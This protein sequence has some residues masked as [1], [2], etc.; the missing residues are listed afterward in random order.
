MVPW[1]DG[2]CIW[3]META[4]LT[5]TGGSREVDWRHCWRKQ[6]SAS[7]EDSQECAVG[8]GHE[9][10]HSANLSDTSSDPVIVPEDHEPISST[11]IRV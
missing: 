3:C 8:T 7:R 1:L 4:E 5:F 10:E 11:S 2:R 6:Q 9:T